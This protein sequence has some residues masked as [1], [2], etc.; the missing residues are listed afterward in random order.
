MLLRF[1]GLQ[2]T[3]TAERRATFWVATMFFASL[4]SM[5]LLRPLRGQL[6]V[7]ATGLA[8]GVQAKVQHRIAP[9]HLA[10]L[11]ALQPLFAAIA[12]WAFQDDQLEAM[13]WVGG[14]LIIAGVVVASRDN[15]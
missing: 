7:L 1:F 3:T 9:A 2:D 6:G 12:G 14:G 8:I 11:F 15:Q 5:F 13:Q 10:L 4:C